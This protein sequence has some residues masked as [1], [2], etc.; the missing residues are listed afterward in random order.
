VLNEYA[1][2]TP[3]LLCSLTLVLLQPIQATSLRQPTRDGQ[4]DFDFEFGSWKAHVS[5]LQRPLTGPTTWV[6][7]GGTSVVRK[8]WDRRA[9]SESSRSMDL[10]VTSKD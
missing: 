9:T 6:D 5:R 2:S 7:Y 1:Y 3:V 10:P 4:H 8:V